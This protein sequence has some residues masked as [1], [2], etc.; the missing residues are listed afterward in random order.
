M[1]WRKIVYQNRQFVEGE[2]T[3]E[4]PVSGDM[5]FLYNEAEDKVVLGYL[6]RGDNLTRHNREGRLFT[7]WPIE[8]VGTPPTHWNPTHWM[9]WPQ[10]P[11]EVEK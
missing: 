6:W 11:K 7:W 1:K 10:K 8:E 9:P 4:L 5:I 3:E 2:I